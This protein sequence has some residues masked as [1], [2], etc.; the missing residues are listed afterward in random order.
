[1]LASV[2]IYAQGKDSTDGPKPT[3][4]R[5]YNDSSFKDF[6]RNRYDVAKAQINRLRH[7]ALLVRLK[8][9]QNTIDKLKAA[10]NIDLAT[11]VA[12]ET[13]QN[14][15]II[16][17]AYVKEFSFCPV[18]FFYSQY[19]DSV[20]HQHLEGIFTDTMLQVN[21]AIVCHADFYLVAEQNFVYSS[22]LGFVPLSQAPLAQERGSAV[23]EVAIVVKNRYFIQLH[24]PFPYYQK[25]YSMKKYAGFVKAFNSKL[26][27]FYEAN[28][29]FTAPSEIRELV[30]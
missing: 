27:T 22:S 4:Y 21:P 10:G 17:R 9:N 28:A 19:S 16:M 2:R 24:E 30:Y 5:D 29:G 15:K 18:Y 20:K 12:R 13:Q 6:S 11:Q 1:M 7:G 14:N 25:G 3:V 23:K 8:T 26:V